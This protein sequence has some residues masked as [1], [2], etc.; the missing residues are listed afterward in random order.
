MAGGTI[1]FVDGPSPDIYIYVHIY[2]VIVPECDPYF[3]RWKNH[4]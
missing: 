4:S 3:L 1:S 2:I